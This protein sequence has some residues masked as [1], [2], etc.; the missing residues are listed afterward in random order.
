MAFCCQLLLLPHT[1]AS[2]YCCCHCC[3]CLSRGR[4]GEAGVAACGGGSGSS[5]VAAAAAAVACYE[6][7]VLWYLLTVLTYQSHVTS[8]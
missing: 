6:N 2:R 5:R 8:L 3:H 4:S 7:R 1:A